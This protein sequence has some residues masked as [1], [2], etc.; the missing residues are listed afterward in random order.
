MKKSENKEDTV[1]QSNDEKNVDSKTTHK[2]KEK[3]LREY[4]LTKEDQVKYFNMLPLSYS[5]K[6]HLY[7][8]IRKK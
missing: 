5:Q 2:T 1:K 7:E 6:Q 3:V 8:S 4:R